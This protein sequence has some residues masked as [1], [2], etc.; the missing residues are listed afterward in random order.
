MNAQRTAFHAAVQYYCRQL[1]IT[2]YESPIPLVYL[3]SNTQ[4]DAPA[5]SETERRSQEHLRGGEGCAK[6]FLGFTPPDQRGLPLLRARKSK[7][8]KAVLRGMN[9]GGPV[10]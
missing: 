7:S 2:A 3:D 10:Q 1:G 9:G 6:S 4:L 8:R 5:I